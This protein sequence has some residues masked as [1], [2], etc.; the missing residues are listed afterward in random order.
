[1]LTGANLD[2][3]ILV[4]ADLTLATLNGVRVA[5]ADFTDTMWSKTSLA[6]A[7][8]L[9]T[10]RGL[11]HLRFGDP[12]AIDVQ[13]LRSALGSLPLEL[14]VNCGVQESDVA[15]LRTLWHPGRA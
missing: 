14:L 13:T 2:G 1:V 11:D 9:D 10:A 4:G 7:V 12:S 3:A 8:G 15:V 5:G 6:R